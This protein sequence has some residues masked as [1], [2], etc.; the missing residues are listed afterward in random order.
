M[1]KNDMGKVMDVCGTLCYLHHID[2]D[3]ERALR[4]RLECAIR[5]CTSKT[6]MIDK[7]DTR[8]LLDYARYIRGDIGGKSYLPSGHSMHPMQIL[9]RLHKEIKKEVKV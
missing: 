9:H 3:K 8:V 5:S 4:E 2:V 7:A 6:A 1:S